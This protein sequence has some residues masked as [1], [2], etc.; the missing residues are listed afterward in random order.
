MDS[1]IK[2]FVVFTFFSKEKLM[3]V[4]MTSLLITVLSLG[5]VTNSALAAVQFYEDFDYQPGLKLT[6][7]T[8]GGNPPWTSNTGAGGVTNDWDLEAGSLTYQTLETSGNSVSFDQ[9]GDTDRDQVVR[10]LPG[11]VGTLFD[12]AGTFYMTVLVRSQVGFMFEDV[13]SNG[14]VSLS[15]D[16]LGG[17]GS[18]IRYF[19]QVQGTGGGETESLIGQVASGSDT[20][21][22]AYRIVNGGDGSTDRVDAVLD[23]TLSLG[24]PDW[25]AATTITNRD[26]TTLIDGMRLLRGPADPVTDWGDIAEFRIATTWNEA[27]PLIPEPATLALLALGGLCLIAR[28]RR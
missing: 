3:T 22:L 8:P 21:M 12:N 17:T 20:H 1:G 15:T 26:I 16:N 24:E 23:P 18:E 7:A 11:G 10:G 28:Q 2:T 5:F 6:D 4:R 13:G 14:R 27:A 25:D 19:L 9:G